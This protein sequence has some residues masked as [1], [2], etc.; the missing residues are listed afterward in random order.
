MI[1]IPDLNVQ[2]IL[3]PTAYLPSMAWSTA[4]W[5]ADI[6]VIEACENYQKGSMRNR[7]HVVGPNGIQ[8]LSIPLVKGKHQQTDIRAVRI[9]YDEAWQRQH[10][11]TILTAYGNAPYFDHYCDDIRPFYE[12]KYAFLFDYN[13]ALMA[14]I[15]TKKM[16]WKGTLTLSET[17]SPPQENLLDHHNTARYPQ[18]F[19][20]KH[21]FVPNMSVLDLLFCCGKHGG[22]ILAKSVT[23]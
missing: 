5:N 15:F 7:A 18:V 13:Q 19:E 8:R 20:E 4:C 12:K 17:Y 3:L 9:A 2:K 16:G 23:G 10:W 6:V 11:R 14:F 22:E 1:V 21:G